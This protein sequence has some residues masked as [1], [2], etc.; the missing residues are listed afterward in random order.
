MADENQRLSTE[1]TRGGGSGFFRRLPREPVWAVMLLA[2]L[3]CA[4]VMVRSS[5]LFDD[6]DNYLPL[7]RSLSTGAGFMLRGHPTAYRPP[8]YP[9]LLRP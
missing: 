5:G 4:V 6:P 2:V 7:A 8:L 1:K 3:L 9:L